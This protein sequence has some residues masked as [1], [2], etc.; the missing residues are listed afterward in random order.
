MN[1]VATFSP[2]WIRFLP[3]WAVLGLL[4]IGC[5]SQ[6]EPDESPTEKVQKA[7]DAGQI[8][9]FQ[10]EQM[11]KA[12][13]PAWTDALGGNT[14][15]VSASVTEDNAL[16]QFYVKKDQIDEV[17]WWYHSDYLPLKFNCINVYIG[18]K[19]SNT[20][21]W[22]RLDIDYRGLGWLFAK[23]ITVVADGQRFDKTDID[24]SKTDVAGEEV[25][26]YSDSAVTE[27]DF[28]MLEAVAGAKTATLRIR[29]ER[30][31]MDFDVSESDRVAI[32]DALMLYK[33]LGGT[34]PP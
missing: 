33:K 26:E 18:E 12:I 14:T 17:T 2:I 6:Q 21:P 28:K 16:D 29:G 11:M 24:F 3:A 1:I 13:N 4:L 20:Q 23:S 7:Y 32:R 19:F 34:E 5:A 10:Y 25:F 15:A 31:N 22:L 8:N 27:D 9:N 30:G